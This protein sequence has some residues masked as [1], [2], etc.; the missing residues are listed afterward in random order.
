MIGRGSVGCDI[1]CLRV[2]LELVLER[3]SLELIDVR[4]CPPEL[5][6]LNH[7]F[8]NAV[9]LLEGDAE[10]GVLRKLAGEEGDGVVA[11]G[12]LRVLDTLLRGAIAR[13]MVYQKRA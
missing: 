11:S 3:G 2:E 8:V 9:K 7:L 1:L 6:R 13:A 10:R 5:E 12:G 4:P